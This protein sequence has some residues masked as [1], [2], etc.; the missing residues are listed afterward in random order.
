MFVCLSECPRLKSFEFTDLCCQRILKKVFINVLYHDCGLNLHIQVL[1]ACLLPLRHSPWG[2]VSFGMASKDVMDSSGW[3]TFTVGALEHRTGPH[4]CW[5]CC[6]ACTC[7][8]WGGVSTSG[9]QC[10]HRYVQYTVN[11]L[12]LTWQSCRCH[13]SCRCRHLWLAFIEIW[14]GH[15]LPLEAWGRR[16][17]KVEVSLNCDRLAL[18]PVYPGTFG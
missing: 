3:Y 14:F 5:G 18:W 16:M 13:G 1:I 17:H 11:C 4:L 10:N 15:F 9:L 8:L 12:V 7:F 2:D 6:G